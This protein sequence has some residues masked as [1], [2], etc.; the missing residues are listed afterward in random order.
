M[1]TSSIAALILVTTE[2]FVPIETLWLA[3]DSRGNLRILQEVVGF[4]TTTFA[5]DRAPIWCPQTATEGLHLGVRTNG[6]SQEIEH[7]GLELSSNFGLGDFLNVH[8]VEIEADGGF[9]KQEWLWAA[10]RGPLQIN[11]STTAG[12]EL[13][14]GRLAGVDF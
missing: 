8:E 13:S 12:W 9:E 4:L 5:W 10:G 14:S 11:E 6:S 3:E 2:D 7:V 1:P